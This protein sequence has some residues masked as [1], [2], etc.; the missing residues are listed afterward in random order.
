M[1]YYPRIL[2]GTHNTDF[3]GSGFAFDPNPLGPH[4]IQDVRERVP[5]VVSKVAPKE[6]GELIYAPLKG[7]H[8][9]ARDALQA[10][11]P[12]QSPIR[13]DQSVTG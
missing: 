10:V 13:R 6:M 5:S 2:L 8:K 9:K 11:Q 12:V 3:N 4:K 7:D 1:S